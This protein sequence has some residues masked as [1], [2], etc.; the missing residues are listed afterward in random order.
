MRCCR[1]SLQSFGRTL[2]GDGAN[3]MLPG[4]QEVVEWAGVSSTYGKPGVGRGRNKSII[5]NELVN[6]NLHLQQQVLGTNGI[7]GV[8]G[9]AGAQTRNSTYLPIPKRVQCGDFEQRLQKERKV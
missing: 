4:L 9:V 1:L 3:V 2:A 7:A 8:A 5:T 6:V